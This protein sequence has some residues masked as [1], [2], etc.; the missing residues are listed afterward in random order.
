[1]EKTRLSEPENI[2]TSSST[3]FSLTQVTGLYARKDGDERRDIF[4]GDLSI[5]IQIC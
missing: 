2:R 1:M 4:E 3:G 5:E